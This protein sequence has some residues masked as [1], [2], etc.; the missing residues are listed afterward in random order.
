MGDDNDQPDPDPDDKPGGLG[1]RVE[2]LESGQA[3]ILEK[4]DA[5]LGGAPAPDP[6]GDP[7]PGPDD[8]PSPTRTL[9][10]EEADVDAKVRAALDKIKGEDDREARLAA[11]EK[12][13]PEKPPVKQ[14]KLERAMWGGTDD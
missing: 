5:L 8:G 1:D 9:R 7:A 10:E 11:L 4:L 14:R 13:V 6:A 2:R 3:S 12:R